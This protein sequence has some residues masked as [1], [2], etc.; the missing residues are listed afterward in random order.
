M[1]FFYLLTRKKCSVINESAVDDAEQKLVELI[2]CVATLQNWHHHCS[3]RNSILMRQNFTP[4]LQVHSLLMITYYFIS[5]MEISQLIPVIKA[6]AFQILHSF[7]KVIF[8]GKNYSI[9]IFCQRNF[10]HALKISK[11][12]L[13][14][15]VN[16]SN[17]D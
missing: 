10:E 16:A 9:D 2:Y 13:H 17:A 15:Y 1:Y 5:S 6:Y 12:C 11:F 3:D 4:P 8:A 7:S 14:T